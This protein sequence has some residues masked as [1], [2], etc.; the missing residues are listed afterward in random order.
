[1]REK[2]IAYV[3]N[4]FRGAPETERNREL[5]EEIL[6]NTLDRFDDAV[7]QGS[8]EEAAYTQAVSS[9]GDVSRLI[10]REKP[11]RNWTGW[12]IGG[13]VAVA[14]LAALTVGLMFHLV[15]PEPAPARVETEVEEAS[16]GDG[17]AEIVNWAV[18]MGT[19]I[20]SSF[21]WD[22]TNYHYDHASSYTAGNASLSAER[23]R[24][25]EI[26]W[27]SGSVTV[28]SYDGDQVILSENE[29]P[30]EAMKLHWWLD[31]KTLRVEYCAEGSHK[32]AA[33][34]ELRVQVP[35]SLADDLEELSVDVVSAQVQISGLE[36]RKLALDS[37][38]G[39]FTVQADCRELETDTVSGGLQFTG[40]A[41]DVSLDTT[42]GSFNLSLSG[43]PDE[44]SFDSTLGGL[45]LAIPEGR[46]FE[47]EMSTVSGSFNC[48]FE[49]RR[50]G[51]GDED[52]VWTYAGS[53]RQS[54]AELEFDTVSG[55][56]NIQRAD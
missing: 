29:Q 36:L 28:E 26:G 20:A 5:R 12:I 47:A 46:G 30:E 21:T 2:L 45:N 8:S 7:A 6:Q 14:A 41:W 13:C 9:I 34:K 1:M 22:V 39:N 37:V 44:L 3:N 40:A 43:T 32:G 10:E 23:I 31:G 38:S 54:R 49:T 42:S 19:D 51:D 18:D 16:L 4:L 35:K 24:E 33:E 17:I 15:K 50:A 11:K 25:I 55:S 53:D 52:E 48:D 27:I 56:V